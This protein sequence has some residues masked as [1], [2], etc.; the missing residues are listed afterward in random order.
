M[1]QNR[2]RNSTNSR[3][4]KGLFFE[5]SRNIDSVVYTLKDRE[6]NGFPSL[7]ELYMKADDDTEYSFAIE[8]LDGWEHWEMLQRCSWFQ[9]YIERWRKELFLKRTSKLLK[10]I[11]AE[12]NDPKSK[13]HFNANKLLLDREW[14]GKVPSSKKRGRPSK[15]ELSAE[16]KQELDDVKRQTADLDRLAE[17]QQR[18]VERD[19]EGST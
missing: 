18:R 19:S 13:N 12:A 8:N 5:T 1:D 6:H 15:D 14:E 16:L 7:Y 17:I 11:Q 2:F 9:P 3:Y 4:L 10:N